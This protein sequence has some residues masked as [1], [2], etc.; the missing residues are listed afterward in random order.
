MLPPSTILCLV[1][2]AELGGVEQ[3]VPFLPKKAM[4]T[5]TCLRGE[6]FCMGNSGYGDGAELLVFVRLGDRTQQG[7]MA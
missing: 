6:M 7:D 1:Y 3:D 5:A 4:C 2:V